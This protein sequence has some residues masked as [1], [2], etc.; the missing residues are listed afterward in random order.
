LSCKL[1]EQALG[2]MVGWQPMWQFH[3]RFGMNLSL[4]V[5]FSDGDIIVADT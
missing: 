5:D 1:I 4:S 2:L 3:V